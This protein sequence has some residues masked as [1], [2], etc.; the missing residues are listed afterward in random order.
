MKKFLSVAF[1]ILYAFASNTLV[2]SFCAQMHIQEVQA[3]HDCCDESDGD[4]YEN[5]MSS[6][7]ESVPIAYESIKKTKVASAKSYLHE[8]L[9]V[10][11]IESISYSSLS[12][13]TVN[14]PWQDIYIWITK[15]VE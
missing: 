6:Y 15:K 5:C 7:D 9:E 14:P 2:H 13:Q 3:V 11:P 12:N 1:L 4:C 8:A 10:Y